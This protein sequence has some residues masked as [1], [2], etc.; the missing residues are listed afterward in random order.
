M[1]P[2]AAGT[3]QNSGTLIP[4]IWSAKLLHK[5]YANTVMAAIANT[6]YEGEI[7]NQGDKVIIRTVPDI[8]IHDYVKHQPLQIQHPETGLVELE[9]AHAH[10]FNVAIDDIDKFQSDIAFMEKWT[11]DGGK[12]LKIFQDRRVLG[13]VYADA[14]AANQGATAGKLTAGFNLGTAGTPLALTKDNVLDFIVDLG[15]VLDEQDIPDE[16][17]KIV[18]PA[19]A[20]ALIKKSDLKDASL[21]G[22]GTSILRNGRVGMVDRFEIYQSNLLSSVVDGANRAFNALACHREAL[23]YAAQ[24][25]K[26]EVVKAESTFGHFARGLLVYGYKVKN[27]EAMVHA[28]IRKG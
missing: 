5:F 12:Q 24:I 1:I 9:I 15:T 13:D 7:A 25:T 2:T 27:P 18:L 22:D 8:E 14:D 3:P 17:R 26:S 20:T 16:M 10:Y 11:E 6:D 28:Y 19:W 23:T 21:A 4:E